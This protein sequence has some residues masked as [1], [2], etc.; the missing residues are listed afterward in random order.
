MPHWQRLTVIGDV[1][2]SSLTIIGASYLLLSLFK[3]GT[4]KLRVRLLVGMVVSDL[5]LGLM[6]IVPSIMWLTGFRFQTGSAGCN[7]HGFFLTII[8]FTQNMWTILIAVGTTLLLKYP[9]SSATTL[10]ERWSFLS[11]PFVI[12]VSV[13]QSGGWWAGYGWVSQGNICYYASHPLKDNLDARD[14][15]QFIP[16]ATVFVIIV[17]AYTRLY[18]FLRRPDTIQLS[19]HF[20]SGQRQVD[21][22]PPPGPARGHL[23]R[24]KNGIGSPMNPDAPWEQMEFVHI[25]RTKL[26]QS[27]NDEAASPSHPPSVDFGEAHKAVAHPSTSQAPISYSHQPSAPPSTVMLGDELLPSP[28]RDMSITS[29]LDGSREGEGLIS[30][31]HSMTDAQDQYSLGDIS[32]SPGMEHANR[33]GEEDG[34]G[35]PGQTMAE[36]FNDCQVTTVGT[37]NGEKPERGNKPL[38]SASAYFNRQASLLMLYFPLAY[39]LVFSMSLVRLVYDMVHK[40]SSPLLGL[41]SAWMVLSVGLIDALVYG[42]AELIVRKRI[43]RKMGDR[44]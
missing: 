29:T 34:E 25:G 36:F 32:R 37:V 15:I 44:I 3:K 6:L 35:L 18:S 42:L 38:M 2:I 27:I 14:L 22:D 26:T 16:R 7:I 12:T 41:L 13:I 4:G 31:V 28:S 40:E 30:S 39:M 1:V 17:T 19:T 43:R 21:V 8:L 11:W 23:R 10:F 20:A 9:L 5:S 33:E 24:N